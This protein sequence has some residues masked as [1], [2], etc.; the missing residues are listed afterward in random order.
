MNQLKDNPETT[1]DFMKIKIEGKREGTGI[2]IYK[3]QGKRRI[4]VYN[5][6]EKSK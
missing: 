5:T 6:K 2:N 1:I 3:R 4:Q